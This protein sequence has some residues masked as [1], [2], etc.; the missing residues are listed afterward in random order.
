MIEAHA[1]E[2]VAAAVTYGS[3]VAAIIF[4]LT[5]GEVTAIIAAA[6]CVMSYL[7]TQ[8]IAVY[9]KSQDLKIAREADAR[10]AAMERERLDAAIA[11]M[12]RNTLMTLGSMSCDDSCPFRDKP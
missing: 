2:K 7:T 4:G 11:A 9:F 1:A 6:V 5:V 8:C 12:Q 3:G 10:H